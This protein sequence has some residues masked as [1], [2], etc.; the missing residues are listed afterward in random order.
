MGCLAVV[1]STAGERLSRYHCPSSELGDIDPVTYMTARP[2]AAIGDAVW[3]TRAGDGSAVCRPAALQASCQ[4]QPALASHVAGSIAAARSP[5]SVMLFRP[6]RDSR[7]SALL[8]WVVTTRWLRSRFSRMASTKPAVPQTR[9]RTLPVSS[10]PPV[11]LARSS[12]SN[13]VGPVV[14]RVMP[15]REQ[16]WLAPHRGMDGDVPMGTEVLGKASVCEGDAFWRH[17]IPG[18]EASSI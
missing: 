13:P 2:S 14:R 8:C 3:V 7:V 1:P 16:E 4:E 9:R 6:C 5:I 18:I 17:Q 11:P 10:H 12:A 15:S